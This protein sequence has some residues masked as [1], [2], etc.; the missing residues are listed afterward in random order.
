MNIL[1]KAISAISPKAGIKRMVDRRR[2][3]ILNS[4]Y[5]GGGANR[6]KQWSKGWKSSSGNAKE[7]ISDNLYTLRQRCRDLFMNAPLGRAPINRVMINAVGTGLVLRPNPDREA[8]GLTDD[9]AAAWKA[10]VVREWDLWA[11]TTSCDASGLNTFAELQQVAL[12]SWLQNGEAFALLPYVD[13]PAEV[14]PMKVRLIEADR[15]C[16]PGQPYHSMGFGVARVTVDGREVS[17]DRG[18]EI[19]DNGEVLAYHVAQRHPAS[20]YSSGNGSNKWERIEPVGQSGR[21]N[22]LHLVVHERAEQYHGVPFLAPVVEMLK[23]LDRYN[24]AELLA[25]VVAGM[26]TVFVKTNT[27][28][29]PLGETVSSDEQVDPDNPNTYEMGPGAV[30]GLGENEA[31]ET[32][33]PTRPN[34]AFEGFVRAIL[35]STGAALNVPYEVMINCYN[36]SYTAARAA[37]LQAWVF[38]RMWRK[39][40]V[41]DFAQPVYREWLTDAILMG[42]IEAPGY[43]D[44]PVIAAAWQRAD[45]HG[46][47]AGQVDPVKEVNAAKVRVAECF[48]T[49]EKEAAE[50]TG[51][52]FA[53]NVQQRRREEESMVGLIP[54]TP[55]A[56]TTGGAN[57][58]E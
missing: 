31:I 34:T 23:Q 25:A 57:G 11:G 44:D 48:S 24:E 21:R 4:G 16:D 1:D 2:M 58:Q 50:M 8:L 3:D 33:N 18:I 5:S 39:W 6:S 37:L 20:I 17:M 45:W 22:I 35:Q 27:P 12:L 41:D 15:I 26:F 54:A 43:F 28:D 19:G 47:S 49:R 51:T 13:R 29:N 56:A 10:K 36:T 42:R 46:P 38:F 14:Y 30:I 53:N 7:D 52:D 55:V 32:A 9:Q 40:T